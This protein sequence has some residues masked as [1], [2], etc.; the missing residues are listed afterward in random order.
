[1]PA[2]PWVE[3]TRR[4]PF[5][6][7]ESH[8]GQELGLSGWLEV[9][10]RRIAAFAD[11]TSGPDGLPARGGAAAWDETTAR[12]LA[13][14]MLPRLA[15]EAYVVEGVVARVNYG[16]DRVRFAPGLRCGARIRDRATLLAVEPNR[17][18]ARITVRNDVETDGGE[19]PVCVADTITLLVRAEGA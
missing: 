19:P 13:L 15:A 4:I 9:D 17:R 5:G 16:L 7:L 1:V 3:M 18:G 10:E 11:A 6:A 8:L 14:S 2:A 12:L